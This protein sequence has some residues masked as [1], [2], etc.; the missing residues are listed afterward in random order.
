MTVEQR[1]KALGL[2]PGEILV[3]AAHIDATRWAVIA[4]DQYTSQLD[5]WQQVEELVGE[6]PSTLRMIVPEV[7]LDTPQ[8]EHRQAQAPR[9]MREYLRDGVLRAL[10]PG[11]VL[12]ERATPHVPQRMGLVAAVDLELYDYT[13]GSTPPIRATEQTIVDRLPPRIAVR[14]QAALESPHILM[15]VDDPGR[16]LIEPLQAHISKLETVY[17]FDLMQGGGHIRGYSVT[18]AEDLERMAAA[19]EALALGA[20]MRFAVGDGNHSLATAK[21]C[22]EQIKPTLTAAQRADHP[23]RFALVEIVNLHDPGIVFH[24]IHRVVFGVKPQA[25]LHALLDHLN[26]QGLDATLAE[27]PSGA[28]SVRDVCHGADGYINVRRSNHPLAVGTLQDAL[29]AV[30]DQL[31]AR[32]DYVHGADVV[33]TL[34]EQADTT[35][36]LLPAMDKDTFFTAVERLGT[37]PRKTFSLGEAEEKRFYLEC[38]A[39]T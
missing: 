13:P 29:D 26:T 33:S 17:D 30:L 31:H 25:L 15:L 20:D 34:A 22:W 6:A 10:S 11:F 18:A 1:L 36:F 37:L 38:R 19:L 14:Q 4:C 39:I 23:A 35:G 3:P 21:A 8:G 5:Y 12:V 28:Q 9:Y 24:P 32:I 2:V 7:Y 16:T 27:R